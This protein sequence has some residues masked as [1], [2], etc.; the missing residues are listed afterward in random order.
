VLS[1]FIIVLVLS[2]GYE[3]FYHQAH[4]LH[5]SARAIG[6]LAL[7]LDNMDLDP[8]NAK[9]TYTQVANE[10]DQ[11]LERCPLEHAECDYYWVRSN[12]PDLFGLQ[13]KQETNTSKERINANKKNL[14]SF[15]QKV[16]RTIQR[17]LF[18]IRAYMSEYTWLVMPLSF[19]IL[20]FYIVSIV[21]NGWPTGELKPTAS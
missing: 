7:N 17:I 5:E 9:L 14:R 16:L 11:I 3:S 10:Y 21:I 19:S 4:I 13:A 1:T 12:R 15:V 8:S 18:W 2:E 6:K 20:T